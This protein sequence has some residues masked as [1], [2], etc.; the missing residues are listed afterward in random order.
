MGSWRNIMK[1]KEELN[2]IKEEVETLNKKLVELNDEELA[3]VFGGEDEGQNEKLWDW[4]CYNCGA[5]G[6]LPKSEAQAAAFSHIELQKHFRIYVG[7]HKEEKKEI[8][9]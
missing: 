9:F 1:S 2:A 8:E 7:P 5:G 3:Q 6:T 4:K